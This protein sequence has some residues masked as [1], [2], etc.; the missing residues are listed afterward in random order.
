M[1]SAL[2]VLILYHLCH[3]LEIFLFRET[4]LYDTLK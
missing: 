4:V 1:L 2:I 3:E